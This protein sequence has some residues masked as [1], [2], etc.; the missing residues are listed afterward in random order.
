MNLSSS[1]R[2]LPL[3]EAFNWVRFTSKYS[4][5]KIVAHW[6]KTMKHSGS[7]IIIDRVRGWTQAVDTNTQLHVSL[8]CS[9]TTFHSLCTIWYLINY[10]ISC[11]SS[12]I[13]L[14]IKH[15]QPEMIAAAVMNAIDCCIQL[16]AKLTWCRVTGHV[17]CL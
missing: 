9:F 4:D 16:L 6:L 3:K 12:S 13:N 14:I 15:N 10:L 5:S 8:K 2:F 1:N 17:K 7:L 11:A